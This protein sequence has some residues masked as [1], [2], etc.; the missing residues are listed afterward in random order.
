MA[1]VTLTLRLT[2]PGIA[3]VKIT[4]EQFASGG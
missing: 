4:G 3:A 1:L 2:D